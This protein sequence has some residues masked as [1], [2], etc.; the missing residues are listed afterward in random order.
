MIQLKRAKK[1]EVTTMSTEENKEI[2]RNFFEKWNSKDRE[3]LLEKYLSP[4]CVMH[5]GD[6]TS[7]E[8]EEMKKFFAS[9]GQAFP[10]QLIEIRDVIAEGDKVVVLMQDSGTMKGPMMGLEPTGKRFSVPAIEVFRLADGKIAEMWEGRD[11]ATFMRQ[12]GAAPPG[13]PPKE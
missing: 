7:T 1:K 8:Y 13:G 2:I 11:M 12:I 5:G 3:E 6:G 10:D 9:L 4:D